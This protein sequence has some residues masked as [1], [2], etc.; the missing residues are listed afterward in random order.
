MFYLLSSV[1]AFVLI[2]ALSTLLVIYSVISPLLP[3]KRVTLNCLYLKESLR[4]GGYRFYGFLAKPEHRASVHFTPSN[5]E[6]DVFS[7]YASFF[8][9]LV[10]VL[11]VEEVPETLARI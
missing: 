1:F 6:E 3:S 7:R 11:I 5:S 4:L 2:S 9:L 10:S 8:S